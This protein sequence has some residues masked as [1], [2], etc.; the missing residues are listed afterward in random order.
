MFETVKEGPNKGE[1]VRLEIPASS[2]IRDREAPR[3]PYAS[4]YG[5][6]VPTSYRVRTIDSRWR[7]V[8]CAIYSNIG[9]CYVRHGKSRTIVSFEGA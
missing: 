5:K 6:A 8:Y 1:L 3:N 9:T 7:R 4:G 2:V